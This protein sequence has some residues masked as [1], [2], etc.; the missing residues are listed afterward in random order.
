MHAIYIYIIQ[1]GVCNNTDYMF[2]N[3]TN[4]ILQSIRKIKQEKKLQEKKINFISTR[5]CK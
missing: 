2:N 4:K 1:N 3:F 5:Y